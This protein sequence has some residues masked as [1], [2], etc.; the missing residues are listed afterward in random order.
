MRERKRRHDDV[1]YPMQGRGK[2]ATAPKTD[3]PTGPKC[4]CGIYR[5]GITHLCSGPKT[6]VCIVCGDDFRTAGET[7]SERCEKTLRYIRSGTTAKHAAAS[8]KEK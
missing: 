1:H 6:G 2:R 5:E 8:G 3:L 7:C 4:E